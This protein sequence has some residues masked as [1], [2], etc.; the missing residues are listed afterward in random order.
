M[1]LKTRTAITDAELP[2]IRSICFIENLAL[3]AVF[4]TSHVF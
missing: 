2:T 1:N 4:F 3:I